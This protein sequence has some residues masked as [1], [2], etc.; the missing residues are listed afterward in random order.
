MTDGD[1]LS[2]SVIRVVVT[3]W[4]QFKMVWAR[5]LL[6]IFFTLYNPRLRNKQTK[7]NVKYI[8]EY[9]RVTL[10]SKTL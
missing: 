4:S 3:T 9:K 5:T 8:Q 2:M 7:K 1:Q 6:Y 10:V